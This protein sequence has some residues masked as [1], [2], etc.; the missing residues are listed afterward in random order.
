M[1]TKNF[2]LNTKANFADLDDE[3]NQYEEFLKK[4]PFGK[5]MKKFVDCFKDELERYDIGLGVTCNELEE[6]IG[7]YYYGFDAMP[8]TIGML[9]NDIRRW[10]ANNDFCF[11]GDDWTASVKL[12]NR[13]DAA[14]LYNKMLAIAT[15]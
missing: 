2:T 8:A 5:T 9:L 14:K 7:M 11:I 12:S 3:M 15:A 4:N 13:P 1:E 6:F 10:L